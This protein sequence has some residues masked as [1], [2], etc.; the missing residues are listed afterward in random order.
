VLASN[1][2]SK[3]RSGLV[4]NNAFHRRPSNEELG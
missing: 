4:C 1:L 2:S 3:R